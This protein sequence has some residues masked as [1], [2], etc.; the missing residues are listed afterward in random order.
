VTSRPAPDTVHHPA[1]D[2]GLGPVPAPG[3]APTPGAASDRPS[4]HP[5]TDG[6]AAASRPLVRVVRALLAVAVLA[7]VVY[8]LWRFERDIPGYPAGNFA[9][10]F[11]YQSATLTALTLLAFALRPS[12]LAASTRAE[13]LRG[14]TV[15]YMVTTGIVYAVLLSGERTDDVYASQWWVNT[16]VHQLL[17]VAVV[18]DW[19]V[20]PPGR[21]LTFRGA[22]WW[23]AYPLAFLVYS[24]VRGPIVDWYPYGFTD[25]TGEGGW[26]TVLIYSA[27]ITV[28][29]LAMAALVV[30]TG[31]R[32]RLAP[33]AQASAPHR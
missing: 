13:S 1:T 33:V 18:L 21:R 19:W 8:Q 5:G 32:G 22:L 17:P 30:R 10:Y 29:I 7:A 27:G 26:G 24:L 3:M 6:P 31:N 15:V 16:L 14:A 12:R 20:T 11:T 23:L 9:S 28:G 25:P 4:G 2:A